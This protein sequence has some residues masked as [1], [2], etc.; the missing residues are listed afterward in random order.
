MILEPIEA[1]VVPKLN[2]LMQRFDIDK[3]FP[4][5]A[6]KWFPL[7]AVYYMSFRKPGP[8]AKENELF[9]ELITSIK[10]VTKV[11]VI[12]NG[13]EYKFQRDPVILEMFQD[14]IDG[15]APRVKKDPKQLA[16][17]RD[18]HFPPFI[19]EARPLFNRLTFLSE[20]K[21]FIFIH[22]LFELANFPFTRQQ[23][24]ADDQ[25][26][27]ALIRQWMKRNNKTKKRS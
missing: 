18:E 24:N 23:L 15:Y 8:D 20:R 21:R 9:D 7:V 17:E 14:A 3:H 16:E 26:K 10:P 11:I 1:E 27:A 25:T 5:M 19:E 2:Q 12:R 13:K 22:N 6:G 4:E